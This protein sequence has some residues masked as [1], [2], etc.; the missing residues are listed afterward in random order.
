V[1]GRGAAR[2]APTAQHGALPLPMRWRGCA[3][4]AMRSL[5]EQGCTSAQGF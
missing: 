3:H 5:D 4:A 1:T 2:S